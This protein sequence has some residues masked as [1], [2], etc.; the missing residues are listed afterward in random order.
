M[1]RLVGTA[2]FMAILSQNAIADIWSVSIDNDVVFDSDDSYTGAFIVTWTGD[3]YSRA[4]EGSFTRSYTSFMSGMASWFPFSDFKGKK[5]NATIALQE[6]IITPDD[7]NETEPVYDDVPYSGTLALHFSLYV[8]DEQE[9]ENYR[10]S[11]GVVGPR[12][13]AEQLQRN[14][15]KI[16]GANDPKGWDNQLGTHYALNFGYLRGIKHYIKPYANGMRLEWASSYFADIGN[17]YVGAGGGSVVRFGGA[18]RT[19]HARQLQPYKHAHEC[20]RHQSRQLHRPRQS[21][22]MVRQSRA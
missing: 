19:E 14:L 4:E 3:E 15:H 1:K 11:A 18:V 8:W 20:V 21:T 9:I 12:S 13:G 5:R 22:G 2:L 6:F 7:I 17:Y 10:I 16:I